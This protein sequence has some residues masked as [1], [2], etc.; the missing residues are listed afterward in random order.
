[1]PFL[2]ALKPGLVEDAGHR[3]DLD[4]PETPGTAKEW[5]TSAPVVD[6][7]LNLVDGTHL[8]CSTPRAAGLLS[9]ASSEIRIRIGRYPD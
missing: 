2:V 5:I 4:L 9:C 3:I 6:P 8:V 1:M 7:A